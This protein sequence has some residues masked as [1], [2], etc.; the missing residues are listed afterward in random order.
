MTLQQTT[1][2]RIW[3]DVPQPRRRHGRSFMRE[4]IETV[5]LIAAIYAFVNL[6]TARFVVDGHSMLPNFDT[7]Q[8]IIVSRLSYILGEPGRG[9]VV[10]FHYPQQ[11]DRDF[12]KRIIGLPGETVTIL[13]GRVYIDGKLIEEPYIENFCRGK[14]CDGEWVVGDDQYFVLGDNRSASKDSQDFGPVDRKYIVGRAFVRYWPPSD[15]GMV[16]HWSYGNNGSPLP[17]M[18]PTPTPHPNP[19]PT[20]TSAPY[21]G[22]F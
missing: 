16:K 19:S 3:T 13:E 5:L 17:T 4:L 8:F 15:W 9:D 11:P 22:G 7:D 1:E 12:I 14:S 10:V 2:E 6:A 20:P 21:F 18:T